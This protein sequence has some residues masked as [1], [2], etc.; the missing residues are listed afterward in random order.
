MDMAHL[1][2]HRD[3]VAL[4]PDLPQFSAKAAERLAQRERELGIV[5]PDSVREWYSLERAVDLLRQHSNSDHPVDLDKLGEPSSIWYGGGDKNFAS[6]GLVVFMCENR[7]VCNW[8]FK[9]DGSPD[10]EV[11]VQVDTASNDKWHWLYCADK[12]NT[13]VHCQIWDH[14]HV[15]DGGIGVSAQ[16]LE[17]VGDD[18][19]FLKAN[20]RQ[21]PSTYGWPGRTNYRFDGQGGGI[22]IWDG[23][24]RGTD[25]FVSAKTPASLD[26]I[27]SQIW[28]CGNL[29]ETLYDLTS[30]SEE[31]L[32]DLHS[33]RTK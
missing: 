23:E 7:G 6:Q 26:T 15:L 27:L 13:F 8:A 12:F 5:F 29:A 16:E 19:E 22:L 2:Y 20:F 1:K 9:L 14:R 4:L 3:A 17:L 10:P 33:A 32:R 18:L 21:R 25:W 11:L 28:R 31:V 30:E 24:D